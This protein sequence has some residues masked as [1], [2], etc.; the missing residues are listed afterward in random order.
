L[1][2]ALLFGLIFALV[3]PLSIPAVFGGFL[4]THFA[5]LPA[6]LLLQRSG[7]KRTS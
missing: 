1:L 4:V 3:R 2:T 5:I 6:L 7:D